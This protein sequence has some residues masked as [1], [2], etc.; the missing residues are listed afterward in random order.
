MDHGLGDSHK[1]V[2]SVATVEATQQKENKYG[3]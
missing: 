3:F 1:T 2:I